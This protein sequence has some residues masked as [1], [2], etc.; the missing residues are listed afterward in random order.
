MPKT[1][2]WHARSVTDTLKAAQSRRTGLTAKEA[3]ARLRSQGRNEIPR[4]AGFS[5]LRILLEQFK[6]PLI[7]ILV[8]AAVV[9]ALLHEF[10]DSMIILA[11]VILN[12]AL[13]YFQEQKANDSIKKLRSLVKH[14]AK[15][16]R[17]GSVMQIDARDVAVGDIV[18]L[19]EGD[20][21]PA[22][23]RLIE[24]KEAHSIEAA[25]TGESSPSKKGTRA[26]SEGT[27]LADREN[28]L[29]MGTVLSQ[30]RALMVV[31]A[32]GKNTQLGKI[33]ELIGSIEEE[34]TP[35]QEQLGK[36]ARI[37]GGA[38]GFIAL[39]LFA[40]GFFS[41]RDI[42][43]MFLVSVAVAVSAIPEGLVISITIILAI[44]MQKILK[45]KALTRRLVAAETLGS[46]SV[47]CTDKTGT[48]TQGEMQITSLVAP[49]GRD[50]AKEEMHDHYFR[51]LEVGAVCNGAQAENLGDG[52]KDVRILGNFTDKAFLKA[53]LAAGLDLAV[54]ARQYRQLEEIPFDHEDKFMATLNQEKGAR[55]V[56]AKGAPEAI[57]EF[58]SSYRLGDK[59]HPLT[60]QV[61][62]GIR[63]HY[64]TLTQKGLRVLAVAEARAGAKQDTLAKDD[65]KGLVLLGFAALKDPL[66]PDI[67]ETLQVTGT[68]GIRPVMIT[69][70]H[71]MTAKAIARE[72]GIEILPDSIMEGAELDNM[73]DKE[74]KGRV[75]RI[76]LYARV[77]PRHK[78]RII[79]AWQQQGAVVA[80]TGDGVNDAPAL[81]KSDVGIALGSG[82]DVAKETADIVLLDDSFKTIVMAIRQGRIIFDNMRKVVVYLLADSFSEV[83]LVVG[84]LLL[85][86]PLPILASQILW[87]NLINDGLPSIA[88]SFE[89][90]ERGIMK[91]KPRQRNEGILNREMKILIFGIGF[92]SDFFLFG[93]FYLL[94]RAA[95]VPDLDYIRTI[96][97]TSVAV[98]SLIY[99]FSI[100]NFSQGIF[101]TNL[102]TNPHLLGAVAISLALQLLAVYLPFLQ[103]VFHTVGIGPLE[104]GI[105]VG[106]AIVKVAG[107]EVVKHFFVSRSRDIT[108]KEKA[109]AVS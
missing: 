66:R 39:A 54:L 34:S 99:V 52:T 81:K 61:A 28:M 13:G 75:K 71:K 90:A 83:I 3:E 109:H 106:L 67:P 103:R 32:T 74:L 97:F 11:A 59:D 107:I 5:R 62:K 100:R 95:G 80:M 47:I 86:L 24:A 53:A 50:L 1:Q 4:K 22:D 68:A 33:S 9:S 76:Q 40:I 73:S 104:W 20:R 105:I 58:C 82:T 63:A 88:L 101:R 15:V 18:S 16:I 48:L 35:L 77:S 98:D 25:L 23:G 38:V 60:A 29:F 64:R 7:Y 21:V 49:D 84:S 37:L 10:V 102:L 79:D 87:V 41:G 72:A 45:A 6:S 108:P 31:V 89:H 19:G 57:L 96:I 93:L 85:G 69:G 65:M 44:G 17:S 78:L 43:E 8:V 92:V 14:Q 56:F 70:D 2:S 26:L 55:S 46:V 36:F 91:R 27:V 51:M 94:L 30:G 42:L 12:T